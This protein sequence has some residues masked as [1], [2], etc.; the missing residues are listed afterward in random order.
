MD[1]R[2]L[3][4]GE[5]MLAAGSA[6]LLVSLFTGWYEA[7]EVQV[8]FVAPSGDYTLTAFEAFSGIELPPQ[9][10]VVVED[11]YKTLGFVLA[12]GALLGLALVVASA[13]QRVSAVGIAGWSVMALIAL[14]LL[15]L[16]LIPTV[17]IPQFH[18]T[19]G[20]FADSSRDTGIWLA[21]AGCM[22]MVVGSLAS[23]RKTP[24][25]A[26]NPHRQGSGVVDTRPR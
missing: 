22:L 11:L 19:R 18:A 9:V 13:M 25:A 8:Q 23:I 6:L 21:L 5:W 16:V 4:A 10:P 15:V 3:R 12:A 14:G 17:R 24:R 2:P 26:G 7:R 1:L 20:L